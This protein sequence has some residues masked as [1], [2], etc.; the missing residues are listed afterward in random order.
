MK[1]TLLI[2]DR[3][4]FPEKYGAGMRTMNFV[5][6]FREYGTVDIAYSATLTEGISENRIFSNGL[7]ACGVDSECGGHKRPCLLGADQR[8]EL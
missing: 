2:C 3:Y 7:A 4:P 8:I 5:R 6:F 1:K